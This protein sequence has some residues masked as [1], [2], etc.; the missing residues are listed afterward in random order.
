MTDRCDAANRFVQL[1]A[2]RWILTVLAE[3]ATGG[4]RYHDLLD[5]V[6]GIP[7]KVLTDTLTTSGTRRLAHSPPR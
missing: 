1:V 6:E 4:H 7:P 5:A 3:L 2:G